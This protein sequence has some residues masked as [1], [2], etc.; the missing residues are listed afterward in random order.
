[1]PKLN[2]HRLVNLRQNA[3]SNRHVLFRSV[4][5]AGSTGSRLPQ[6]QVNSLNCMQNRQLLPLGQPI[7]RLPVRST[8]EKE[9]QPDF[10]FNPRISNLLDPEFHREQPV[11]HSPLWFQ[12]RP[13][14]SG[15]AR[16]LH[17]IIVTVDGLKSVRGVKATVRR[18]SVMHSMHY[19]PGGWPCS[20]C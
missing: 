17:C 20:P 14:H 6:L 3:P 7:I 19:L 4:H 15:F 5:F 1:M 11:N 12:S 16:R 2:C 18:Q 9:F 8:T 10:S 13:K